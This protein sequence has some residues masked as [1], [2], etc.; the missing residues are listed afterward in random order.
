MMIKFDN[1]T[2]QFPKTKEPAVKNLSMEIPK[3]QVTVLVGPSGC[4]KTT[5]MKMVNRI[6]ELTGGK[7]YVDGQDISQMNPI[8]L[9]LNIGYVIQ[10]IGLFPHM[11]I[12]DNVATVLYEKKWPKDKIQERVDELL[13]LMGLDPD[14]YRDRRPSKLSGGQRQR[15]G[16]ARAM[17]ANPPIMLMDEPFAAVDPITRERLQN[18]F[19]EL[20]EKL[21]KTIIFVTHDINE[22]IKMGDMIAVMRDGSLIQYDTPKNL[23]QDPADEFVE[24]LVGSNRS[25]KSLSLVMVDDVL[26]KKVPTL[27]KDATLNKAKDKLDKSELNIA[28][29]LE[30]QREVAG[31]VSNI[32]VKEQGETVGDVYRPYSQMLTKEN[33]LS[34]AL[35]IM[36]DEHTYHVAIVDDEGKFEGVITIEDVFRAVGTDE[37]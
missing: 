23:L 31:F 17:A 32:D 2:K 24:N 1:V 33:T 13:D 16:V 27:P 30:G 4:G 5:S 8:E 18:E 12:A 34:E 21:N 20:Q 10:E 15:V 36:L 19:L 7:I 6:Y 29:V 3:G 9:R 22:A 25:V 26:R 28:L 37:Y 14:I 35:S 11:S